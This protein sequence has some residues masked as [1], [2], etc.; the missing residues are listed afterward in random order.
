MFESSRRRTLDANFLLVIRSFRFNTPF[1]RE[2]QYFSPACLN[3]FRMVSSHTL[4]DKP[5]Y[6]FRRLAVKCPYFWRSSSALRNSNRCL[7]VRVMVV[8][9]YFDVVGP[10][11]SHRLAFSYGDISMPWK[12]FD[13]YSSNES[14][15]KYTGCSDG[16]TSNAKIFPQVLVCCC[17]FSSCPPSCCCCCCCLYV[18]K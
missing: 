9:L 2:W 13:I 3:T 14:A 1:F 6:N 18:L 8:V 4:P 15:S 11:H 17:C 12:I 5:A 16:D 7:L 10:F